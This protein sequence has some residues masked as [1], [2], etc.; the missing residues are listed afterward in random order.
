MLKR[1]LDK[2]L[3][4]GGVAIMDGGVMTWHIDHQGEA[5]TGA[6]WVHPERR[7]QGLGT[8]LVK[9]VARQAKER[10]CKFLNSK[11]HISNQAITNM[12]YRMGRKREGMDAEHIYWRDPIDRIAD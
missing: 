3:Q 2:A 7:R 8:A 6:L 5:W 11:T 12:Y 10:G 1:A 9:E 4:D